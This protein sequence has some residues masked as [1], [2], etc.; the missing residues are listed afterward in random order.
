MSIYSNI[1]KEDV[2]LAIDES[3]IDICLQE[4]WQFIKLLES[5]NIE[6]VEERV[7]FK[8][9]I[10]KIKELISKFIKKI[11]IMMDKF[12]KFINP[13]KDKAFKKLNDT[14]KIL[15]KIDNDEYLKRIEIHDGVLIRSRMYWP[16][17]PSW[18]V[19]DICKYMDNLVD[20]IIDLSRQYSKESDSAAN[21]FIDPS[22]KSINYY[23]DIDNSLQD[24][25]NKYKNKIEDIVEKIKDVDIK[26][27]DIMSTKKPIKD[28]Q[29]L[30]EEANK[31]KLLIDNLN[32][33]EQNAKNAL[34][35]EE[36]I[37]N[38]IERRID[39]TGDKLRSN[40]RDLKNYYEHYKLRDETR[41]INS[42]LNAIRL[43]IIEFDYVQGS[44]INI[45]NFIERSCTWFFIE[46]YIHQ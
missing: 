31:C 43:E 34:K 30:K 5:A 24:V 6:V 15:S 4:D 1:L 18:S 37:V 29:I 21:K 25:F 39:E 41:I 36:M 12:I 42:I 45:I 9:V 20:D 44:L 14:E 2:R 13:K 32:K 46:L 26:I 16:K 33:F 17:N 35:K 8:S 7:S 22:Y 11:S 19:I 28:Y 23:K 38:N 40:Y 27:Q 10:S 3:Y